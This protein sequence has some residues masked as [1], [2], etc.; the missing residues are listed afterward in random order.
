MIARSCSGE[1]VAIKAIK[2]QREAHL[3]NGGL[4]SPGSSDDCY[5]IPFFPVSYSV[6]PKARPL[7]LRTSGPDERK[8]GR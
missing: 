1:L 4:S 7:K 5:K 6:D 2:D 3:M 8:L